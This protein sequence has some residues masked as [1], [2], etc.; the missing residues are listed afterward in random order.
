MTTRTGEIRFFKYVFHSA[1]MVVAN[2][3]VWL[4]TRKGLGIGRTY[5]AVTGFARLPAPFGHFAL[6]DIN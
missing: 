3:H 1:L 6:A 4:D 2:H 5:Q